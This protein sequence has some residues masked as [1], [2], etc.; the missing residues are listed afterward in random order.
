MNEH[1]KFFASWNTSLRLPSFTEMYYKLQGYAADPHLKPEEMQAI[2]TGIQ[3]HSDPV[4][5][6]ATLYY[7]HGKNMIDWIM[8]TSLGSAASW[9]STNHTSINTYGLEL[10][11]NFNLQKLIPCQNTVQSF[12]LSYAYTYQDKQAEANIVSQYALEYLRH[13]LVGRLTITPLKNVRFNLSGRF[14]DREG[15]YTCFD[16]TVS[17]Y[18][19]YVL[20][21]ARLSWQLKKT[22]IYGEVN[23]LLNNRSWVDFGNVP[24]PGIWCILGT[25][26]HLF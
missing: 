20:F 19:P 2:E 11:T 1:F 26:F 24:Q 3:W 17:D 4:D 16:G 21:D 22:E 23:N 7:H 18:R 5:A 12:S 14:Q 8:D 6:K 15:S 10:Y 9:E 25:Y 13:K